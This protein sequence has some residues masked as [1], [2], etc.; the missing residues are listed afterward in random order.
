VLSTR[1][2][3]SAA[4]LAD[5]ADL[6]QRV[7]DHDG[8]RLKLE[9][10]TLRSRGG[11]A[12]EDLL[13]HHDERLM[14]FL[15][16]YAFGS[17]ELELAGMVDPAARRAGIGTALVDAAAE[18]G[19]E[20]G[21]ARALLVTPRT[22]SAG[23]AFAAARGARL[24]HS[25]HFMSLDAA[26]T[27]PP[28]PPTVSLRPAVATDLDDLRRILATAFGDAPGS[29]TIPAD[30]TSERTLMV[31]QAGAVVGTV[32]IAREG[33]TSGIYGLAVDPARQGE[34]IGREVLDRAGREEFAAGADRV[35]LE[36]AVDNDR[37]LGLYRSVGFRPVATEDY[38]ALPLT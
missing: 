10:A 16:L 18:I 34:G 33:S 9:W 28:P 4:E 20:R 14:G 12:V 7:V 3:L 17:G 24:A 31:E 21:R 27:G 29:V 15:G 36:V 22:T 37:A 26:P 11:D 25:E 1:R 6:A 8:G 32:R 35:T 30:G 19:R 13:W 5:V 2:A 38:F 23:A